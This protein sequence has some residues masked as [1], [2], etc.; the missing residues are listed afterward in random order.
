MMT[1]LKAHDLP[2]AGNQKRFSIQCVDRLLRKNQ[3]LLGIH[4]VRAD[5]RWD[6]VNRLRVGLWFTTIEILWW[7]PEGE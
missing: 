5:G 2:L 4:W 1:S 6:T 3:H 7:P